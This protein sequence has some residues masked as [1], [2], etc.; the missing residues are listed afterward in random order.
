MSAFASTIT[1][2][3]QWPTSVI[4]NMKMTPS[5]AKRG[6]PVLA[7]L[8]SSTDLQMPYT[9]GVEM[10][11]DRATLRDDLLLWQD[12]PVDL[13]ALRRACPFDDVQLVEGKTTTGAP[14]IRIVTALPGSADVSHHPFQGEIDE[15]VSCVLEDRETHLNVHDAEITMRVCLAVDTSASRGGRTV[16]LSKGTR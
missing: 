2:G 14:A 13:A 6:Q 10:M 15:L 5:G 11:G 4:A 1:A 9:F 3:Y 7:Q 8:V 16:K 12:T